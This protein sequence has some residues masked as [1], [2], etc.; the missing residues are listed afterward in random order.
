MIDAPLHTDTHQEKSLKSKKVRIGFKQIVLKLF[1]LA[2]MAG[3]GAT[4]YLYYQTR[5]Q[6]KY[7]STAQ[8]QEAL[9]KSEVDRI[10][11][12]LKKLTLLP[13]E[14]PVIATILD[15]QYLAT[16]S[17]FY[18]DA[19]KGD[20]IVVYRTAQKA[21]IYSPTRDII[22]NSGPLILDQK[23]GAQNATPVKL[24]IRNGSSTVGAGTR[25]SDQLKADGFEV[26]TVGSAVN[27]EYPR[28]VVLANNINISADGLKEFA[29]KINA[30]VVTS[31]PAGEAA[32]QAD[33]L[34]II[35]NG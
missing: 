32:T 5:E 18:K 12:D 17:A 30:D 11:A 28:T 26:P 13:A 14:E 29:T 25:L 15:E 4:G 3:L 34:I 19:Q 23:A 21:F 27:Q 1:V 16:Q 22:V 8:G 33:I 10:V 24:E 20:K 7:L 35:G 6:L 31:P 9:A 2:L